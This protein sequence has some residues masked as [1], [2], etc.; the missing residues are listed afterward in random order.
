MDK[1][2]SDMLHINN[3]SKEDIKTLPKGFRNRLVDV[4]IET[5]Q[6]ETANY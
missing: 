2:N 4:A 5:G 6:D 1:M 3:L